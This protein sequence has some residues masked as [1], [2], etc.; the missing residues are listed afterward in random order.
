MRSGCL[1]LG[2]FITALNISPR[3][4]PLLLSCLYSCTAVSL[5]LYTLPVNS[6]RTGKV[7]YILV[8]S[9]LVSMMNSR[10]RLVTKC[11]F[12][13]TATLTVAQM[14]IAANRYFA[15][16]LYYKRQ[17]ELVLRTFYNIKCTYKRIKSVVWRAS[18]N[19][20]RKK[21][22]ICKKK[23]F[24][25]SRNFVTI[26]ES[27]RKTWRLGLGA[28][29]VSITSVSNS[30]EIRRNVYLCEIIQTLLKKMPEMI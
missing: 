11:S 3:L 29:L 19:E 21:K 1:Q 14:Q 2:H 8:V 22:Q 18:L 30:R 23:N 9:Q 16:Y 25:V 12:S 6:F 26:H 20:R 17:Q 27:Y 4:V 7:S 13:L 15:V 28:G 10:I 24:R 5:S